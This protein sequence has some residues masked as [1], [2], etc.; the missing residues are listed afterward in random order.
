MLLT[1]RHILFLARNSLRKTLACSP[2][3]WAAFLEKILSWLVLIT[4][5]ARANYFQEIKEHVC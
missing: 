5:S 4:S 1:Y 2:A 3:P